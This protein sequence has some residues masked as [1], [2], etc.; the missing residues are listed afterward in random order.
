ME[1]LQKKVYISYMISWDSGIFIIN[2]EENP[3]KRYKSLLS[4]SFLIVYLVSFVTDTYNYVLC[5]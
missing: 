3:W 2:K 5:L 1:L 4:I